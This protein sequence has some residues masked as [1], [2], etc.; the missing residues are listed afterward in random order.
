MKSSISGPGRIRQINRKAVLLHIRHSGKN[1]RSKI[2]KELGLSP[3]AMTSVVNEL[4]EEGLLIKSNDTNIDILTNK[5]EKNKTV[6]K[7]KPQGRPISFLELNPHAACAYGILLLPL[8]NI[9]HIEAAWADYTGEIHTI[10]NT[11]EVESHQLAS[12]IDGIKQTLLVLEN[13]SSQ[14][15]QSQ[16]QGLT[17]GIPGVVEN[18]NIPIAPKLACIEG[19]EF[20]STLRNSLPYPVSFENDVNLGAMSELKQQPRLRNLNFAYLH[21]YSGVGSSIVIKGQILGGSRGWAGEIGQLGIKHSKTIRP[22]FEQ[23]LSVDGTLADLL[24]SFNH[25]RDALDKL[26]PYIDQKNK[27]VLK[28][29][30]KYSHLLFDAI[31]VL[32]S[33]LDLDE[34]MIDFP[35]TKL[36]KK[37]LPKIEQLIDEMPH[38]LIISTPTIEHQADL[39]G[40]AL[41][42]LNLA[43][44]N[45]EQRQSRN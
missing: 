39:H 24:E 16:A 38:K 31:N 10:K 2:G 30:E 14:N 13:N 41:N 21:V 33:V 6:A 22:S 43:L 26:V 19:I 36:F 8:G 35:S 11:I 3:A 23:L 42:A 44:E 1:S 28:E 45:I 12:I 34:I 5:Q 17:I 29:T 25:P 27:T 15:K 9:C 7:R 37:L 40:A 20:M 4:I 32:H 18:D